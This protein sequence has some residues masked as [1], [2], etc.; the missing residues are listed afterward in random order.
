[1]A[2]SKKGAEMHVAIPV[3]SDAVEAVGETEVELIELPVESSSGFLTTER[4]VS[5]RCLRT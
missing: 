3:K 2:H 5:R 4:V 1:M